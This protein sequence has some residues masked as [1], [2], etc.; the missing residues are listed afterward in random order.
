MN[1]VNQLF[2]CFY[3]I[4]YDI[5]RLSLTTPKT[6]VCTKIRVYMSYVELTYFYKNICHTNL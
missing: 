2:S 3:T 4:L 5:N 6:F 1:S